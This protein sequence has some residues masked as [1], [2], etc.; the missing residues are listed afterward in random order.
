MLQWVSVPSDCQEKTVKKRMNAKPLITCAF[1]FIIPSIFILC[2]YSLD[3]ARECRYGEASLWWSMEKN[4]CRQLVGDKMPTL[5]YT[6]FIFFLL[7]NLQT[8][9]FSKCWPCRKSVLK[10]PVSPL[11]VFVWYLGNP[12]TFGHWIRGAESSHSCNFLKPKF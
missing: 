6:P 8:A 11:E 3:L 12:A 7:H 5:T 9:S 2:S 1:Q 4:K 10:Q